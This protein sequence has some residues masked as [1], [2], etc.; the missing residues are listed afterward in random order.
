MRTCLLI[1]SAAIATS[2]TCSATEPERLI[3]PAGSPVETARPGLQRLHG[4]MLY[5]PPSYR[6][7]E[8]LPLLVLLH[9]SG[10]T[11]GAWFSGGHKE[12][13][14]SFAA[15]ADA[16]RFII[17]A[18]DS[19]GNTWGAGPRSFG[20]DASAINRAL[21]TA[22]RKCAIDRGRLA[23]GGFSDG[24]SYALSLAIANGDI[25]R[26]V[27]AFS[28]GYFIGKPRR[29]N[30]RIFISHGR[31][32]F[33]LPIDETSRR[34]VPALKQAGYSVEYDEFDGAHEAPVAVVNHAM[35]WLVAAFRTSRNARE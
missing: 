11:S 24:A 18:P 2:A 15:L 10:G 3:V 13:P 6:P 5:V 1:F 26:E 20:T 25:F 23:L 7:S 27:M 4:A 16:H 22:F 12:L 29:G 14:S 33:V 19:P 21:E 9:Y 30:P 28:P 32:D 35:S 8:P 34:F 17:L 31:A